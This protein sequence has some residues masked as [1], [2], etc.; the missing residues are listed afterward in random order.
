MKIAFTT[1]GDSPESP[2]DPRFGRAAGFLVYDTGTKAFETFGNA[3]NLN[4]V[5]GAGIQA[6]QNLAS[7]GVEALVTGH[8]GPK[9][10]MVLS[11]AGIR[12]YNTNLATVSQALEAYRNGELTAA[13]SADSESHW[14]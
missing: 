14:V 10:F 13:V 8:C 4:A 5:Q 7:L 12:V 9:A 1:T 6:A 3:Q 2:L 11:K